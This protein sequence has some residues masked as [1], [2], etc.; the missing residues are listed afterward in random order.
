MPDLDRFEQ[1]LAAE[2]DGDLSPE[3]AA[4]LERY[5]DESADL[6]RLRRKDRLLVNLVQSRGAEHAPRDF[7]Q[8]VMRRLHSK[9]TIYP[10]EYTELDRTADPIPAPEPV[11]AVIWQPSTAPAPPWWSLL[12]NI[13]FIRWSA[14]A[15][16]VLFFFMMGYEALFSP[17]RW[18]PERGKKEASGQ[19]QEAD[20][21]E[22]AS[23][24]VQSPPVAQSS[25]PEPAKTAVPEPPA[26]PPQPKAAEAT[27]G[28]SKDAPTSAEGKKA[29]PAPAEVLVA[30]VVEKTPSEA[31]PVSADLEVRKASVKPLRADEAQAAPRAPRVV[32]KLP[33]RKEP[34]PDPTK[35]TPRSAKKSA[36][37]SAKDSTREVRV[38]AANTPILQVGLGA[39]APEPPAHGASSAA[40][41]IPN[42]A[43]ALAAPGANSAHSPATSNLRDFEIALAEAG[44]TI[45]QRSPDP[46]DASITRIRCRI[47]P[48][49]L[50]KFLAALE[51]KGVAP[52]RR[53]QTS[54]ALEPGEAAPKP[55]T[56]YYYFQRRGVLE[57]PSEV[58][59]AS[60]L[61]IEI[62]V[63]GAR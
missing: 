25:T 16:G 54:I 37:S 52:R 5:C 32:S 17:T 28:A 13:S 2:V 49:Q 26:A 15:A 3:E 11:K 24:P 22:I 55:A 50:D 63:H 60:P 59:A 58:P 57:D 9:E 4:E 8:R 48:A 51:R 61:D 30:K 42:G 7:S 29:E 1:L 46:Q 12:L 40:S 62:L 56:A 23:A 41:S 6:R 19:K 10:V 38:A 33:P 18:P 43:N 27:G 14:A 39:E 21:F 35:P 47:S 31:A 45:L 36:P 44:G 34:T 20:S 53:R